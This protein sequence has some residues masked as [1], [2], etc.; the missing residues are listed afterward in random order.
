MDVSNEQYAY[1]TALL[2]GF[3]AAYI[4]NKY[5]KTHLQR[6]VFGIVANTITYLTLLGKNGLI[7][8]FIAPLYTLYLSQKKISPWVAF[9]VLYV[10][11]AYVQW[12]LVSVVTATFMMTVLR[13]VTYTWYMHEKN[14]NT[15]QKELSDTLLDLYG[16][17][18]GIGGFFSG[19]IIPYDEYAKLPFTP[20]PKYRTLI[21]NIIKDCTCFVVLYK[22]TILYG[23]SIVTTPEWKAYTLLYKLTLLPIMSLHARLKY[24]LIWKV[25]EAVCLSIGWTEEQAKNVDIWAVERAESMYAMINNWNIS[26]AKYLKTCV[27]DKL[28]QETSKRATL[29]TFMLSAFWHGFYGGYYLSFASGALL[30][31]T[32][33]AIRKT[34]RPLIVTTTSNTDL[35]VYLRV[36]YNTVGWGLTNIFGAY[37]MAPF[38][39]L[40]F[41]DSMTFY[42]DTY[43]IGHILCFGVLVLTNAYRQHDVSR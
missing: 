14:D 34:A 20:N 18:F 21:T 32:S 41:K 8:V 17:T 11:L 38:A 10:H 42:K 6:N 5:I 36:M 16:Y 7:H 28:R 4:Q 23:Y 19:P 30:L 33:R 9:T 31:I 27:Y 29:F 24:Y 35:N 40:T 15:K 3:P 43:F 37:M 39:L 25:A 22:V 1:L 26:T 12:K 2:M 13:L